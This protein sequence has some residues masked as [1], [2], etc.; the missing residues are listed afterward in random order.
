MDPQEQ[1]SAPTEEAGRRRRMQLRARSFVLAVYWA[2]VLWVILANLAALGSD[3]DA[4]RR[5]AFLGLFVAYGAWSTARLLRA[6]RAER[7]PGS[8]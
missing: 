6:L 5:L 8:R 7:P 2:V 4:G 3:P 1:R